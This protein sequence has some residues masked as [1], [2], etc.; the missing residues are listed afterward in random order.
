MSRKIGFWAVFAFV[1]GSQIGS[2]VFMLPASLAAFGSYSLAGWI[3][4]GLGAISLALVFA[5]LC[6]QYP[7]T[8]GPH[9]YV[10]E[11]FGAHAA[12]FAGWTYWVISWISTTAVIIASIGYLTPLIGDHS[13]TTN[14]ILQLMLLIIIT[15]LNFKGVKA[16]G[17]AEF[18]LT[19]L[20]LIPLVIM[21]VVA[22]FFFDSNNY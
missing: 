20:K 17:N 9:V 10:K 19:L 12:F 14:L 11:A 22:L 5:L 2:G 15:A 8:G 13:A 21:P 16:A 3:I 7:K 4:S 1:T 18:I 6:A